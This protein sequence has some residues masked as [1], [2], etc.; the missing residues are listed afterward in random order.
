MGIFTDRPC[1]VDFFG[2]ILS[3]LGKE[4]KVSRNK[5]EYLRELSKY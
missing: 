5:A 3:L 4:R 1:F 2:D